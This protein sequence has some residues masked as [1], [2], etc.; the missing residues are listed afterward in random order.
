MEVDL[1][2]GQVGDVFHG[3][4]L[5]VEVLEEDLHHPF[6]CLLHFSE[7]VQTEKVI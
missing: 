2:E 4:R 7:E 6:V 3:L 5:V 1:P